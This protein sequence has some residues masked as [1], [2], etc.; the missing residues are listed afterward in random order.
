MRSNS[1]SDP[2]PRRSPAWSGDPDSEPSILPWPDRERPSVPDAASPATYCYLLDADPDLADAFD[3]RTRIVVRQVAT[4]ATIELPAGSEHL[5]RGASADPAGLGLLLLD[6]ILTLE[7]GVGDR[8]AAELL[9]PGDLLQPRLA[10]VDALL[11]YRILRRPLTDCRLAVLDLEFVDRIR[12]WPQVTL[13]LLRR[14]ERRALDVGVQRAI[15]SHP[16]LEV[17]LALLLWHLGARWGRVESGGVRLELP[18][19]HALLGHLVAA[20]RP[21]VSRSLARL[22]A[23]GLVTGGAGDW[24]L[25]GSAEHC[26]SALVPR[27][28][29]SL[30]GDRGSDARPGRVTR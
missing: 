4:A 17:R 26:M 21:S 28:V 27:A 5:D 9:G 16:S 6:G 14:C 1:G 24:H 13:T 23:Q 18:L 29:Q 19:T 30:H 10:G 12:P 25:A 2:R 8:A 15:T 11:E 20:E 22:A 7:V 3:L